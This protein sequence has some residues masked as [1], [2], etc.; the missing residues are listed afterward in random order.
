MGQICRYA[1]PCGWTGV[2]PVMQLEP[3][4]KPRWRV[5][6]V[7]ILEGADLAR[8][9]EHAGADRVLFEFLACTGLRIGEALGLL[10][11]TSRERVE[12]VQPFQGLGL[13]PKGEKLVLVDCGHQRT[14]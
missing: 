7:R 13:R 8:L 11:R 14:S 9:L 4:E 5:E 3:G 2:N 12:L 1:V 6:Q 10:R